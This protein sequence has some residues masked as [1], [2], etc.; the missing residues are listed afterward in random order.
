[1]LRAERGSGSRMLKSRMLE[2]R[3]V[4]GGKGGGAWTVGPVRAP[5]EAAVFL[6]IRGAQFAEALAEAAAPAA[7]PAMLRRKQ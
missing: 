6:S 3:L 1:M 7:D 5:P 2:R 4:K